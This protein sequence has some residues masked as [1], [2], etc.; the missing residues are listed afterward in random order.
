MAGLQKELCCCPEGWCDWRVA[1]ARAGRLHLVL[2]VQGDGET[3]S[4]SWG[5]Q[6]EP[7]LAEQ[8]A[9][10][11][12]CRRSHGVMVSTLDSESSD[13]SSSLSGTS[14]FFFPQPFPQHAYTLTALL[15]CCFTCAVFSD[16]SHRAELEPTHSK[17][18]RQRRLLW[19]CWLLWQMLKWRL[20]T[21]SG[22]LFPG[23]TLATVTA[24][25]SV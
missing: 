8:G 17:R 1:G 7:G 25:Y 15:C 24:G 16:Q 3:G 9:R 4:L 20:G 18:S 14:A 19:D 2:D 6:A 10:G 23:W 22:Q 5:H 11:E 12:L 21:H 13:L